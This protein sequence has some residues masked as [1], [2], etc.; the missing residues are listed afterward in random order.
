MATTLRNIGFLLGYKI[1][2]QSEQAVENSIQDLKNMA[3]KALGAIGIGFSLV[4]LNT[5][6]E[7][8]SRIKNQIRSATA[9]LGDQKDIQQEILASATATRTSYAETAKIISNLV[10]ENAELFG[11]VDEAVK[12]NNAATMLFKTAGKSNEQ[13]AGLMEAIN[14]SF[15]KGYVD[16]ETISQLLEQSPE[17]VALLNERLGT[18]SDQLEEMAT[19]GRMTVEDLKM[20][21]VENADEIAANFAGVKLTITDA[22]VVIRNKWG[23]WLSDMDD[24]LGLTSA[25]ATAIVKVSDIAMSAARK[26]QT[27]LEWLSEKLGGTE[28]LLKLVAIA[29]GAIFVAL[30]GTKI[31]AFLKGAGSLLSAARLKTLAIVAVIVLLALLVEDFFAFMKGE[32]SLIGEM[33]GRAGIDTNALRENIKG[34]WSQVKEIVPIFK[35]F[36]KIVGGQLLTGIKQILP[37]LAELGKAVLPILVRLIKQVVSFVGQLAQSVLPMVASLVERLLPFLFQ[38]IEIILPAICSLIETLLPLVMEIIE[39]VLPIIIELL[40]TLLPII[41]QIVEAV[42]PILLELI[43]LIVPILVQIIEA[44]L[45]VILELISAILPI[46]EPI[47]TIISSLVEAVLPL[48]VSLLGAILPILEPI[49]GILQ[50]IADILGV[51][52]GAIAK[53]VGWIADGLGWVVDLIFGSGDA[54]TGNADKVN[55]YAKGTDS[56]SDTFIAGEEGPELITGAR[57]R[58]VFTALE[59]GRIFQAMAMLGRAAVARP[60]TVMNSSSS[61]TINQY[62]RFESTFN[63][64]RAGQEKSAAAMGAASDDAVSQMARALAF[65]R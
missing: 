42:L 37:R 3:T 22:L 65:T 26:I 38:V 12:F 64:D 30:N 15:A 61:R 23:L 27:R 50:P 19:D 62:N 59:T 36:A 21:F 18:T 46:L 43:Q 24:T 25:I 35:Q 56:S 7:E 54:D 16:S 20:A 4:Q 47:F 2:K 1:D 53:V 39:A 11:T 58:K 34:L 31:L 41:M 17:A 29:S 48:L 52:I 9:E 45:P 57:G 14:K 33:L 63:G 32:N 5:V 40:N 13:I 51:I 55:A 28:Q 6:V 49:L 44:I 10:H 8:F 60:S